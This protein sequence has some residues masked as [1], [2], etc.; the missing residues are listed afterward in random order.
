MLRDIPL[1]AVPLLAGI[2]HAVNFPWESIQ[3]NNT[4]VSKFSGV[5][6]GNT[7]TERARRNKNTTECRAFPGSA[8]WPAETDWRQLN[9][10]LDGSLLQ[11][12]PVGEVCY[13]GPAYDADRCKSLVRTAGATRLYIDDPLTS[14]TSWTQGNTC[15]AS[16][17]TRGNCTRGGF[18]SYVVNATNVKQIQAAVNFARNKNLRLVIK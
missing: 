14:L 9:N 13:P 16:L 17:T 12:R 10:I 7:E 1:L 2:A 18:P 3:L 5:A 4:H 8:D 15:L 11:P 6:F